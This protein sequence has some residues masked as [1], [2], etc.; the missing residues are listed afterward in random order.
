MHGDVPM[1]KPKQR[2]KTAVSP[3]SKDQLAHVRGGNGHGKDHWA[4][5]SPEETLLKDDPKQA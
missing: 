4:I 3:I 1:T 2:R 5:T